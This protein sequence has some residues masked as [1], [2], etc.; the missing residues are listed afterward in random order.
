MQPEECWPKRTWKTNAGEPLLDD[1]FLLAPGEGFSSAEMGWNSAGM[2]GGGFG[3]Q[4]TPVS[5]QAPPA[6]SQKVEGEHLRLFWI[7]P[8]YTVADSN[9]I[10]PLTTRGRLAD[11][12][13]GGFFGIFLFPSV[14]HQD[15]ATIAWALDLSRNAS[16]MHSYDLY[17]PTKIQVGPLLTGQGL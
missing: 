17:C 4:A 10:S 13:A 1:P 8:T 5:Q 15:H 3:G 16:D 12:T 11:E 6:K 7:F 2:Y 14:L 9:S